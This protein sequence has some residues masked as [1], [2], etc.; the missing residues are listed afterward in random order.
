MGA[1]SALRSVIQVPMSAN[2]ACPFHV[3]EAGW[4]AKPNVRLCVGR[5]VLILMV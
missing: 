3:G 5:S 2:V 4:Y 1:N